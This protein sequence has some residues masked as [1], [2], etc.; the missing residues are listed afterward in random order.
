MNSV[1]ATFTEDLYILPSLTTVLINTQ[2]K[3]LGETEIELLSK[4]LNSVKLSLAAVRIVEMKSLDLSD[5]KEKPSLLIGFGID[6]PGIATYE[7]VATPETQLVLADSLTTLL[8][9]DQLKKKLWISLKQLF[10]L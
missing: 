6:A 2:W 4:I 3:D 10:S 7:V 1:E 8:G 9:E 5:L